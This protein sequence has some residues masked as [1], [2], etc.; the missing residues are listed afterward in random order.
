M[1]Q[2]QGAVVP[3]SSLRQRL[4]YEGIR[5]GYKVVFLAVSGH[6]GLLPTDDC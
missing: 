4:I 6:T 1:F 2:G 3:V 5:H